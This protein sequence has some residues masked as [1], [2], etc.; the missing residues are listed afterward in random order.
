MPTLRHVSPG[1]PLKVEASTFNAFV[2]AAV[3]AREQR[4]KNKFAPRETAQSGIVLVQNRSGENVPQY[5]VLGIDEPLILPAQNGSEFLSRVM[6]KGVKPA[7]ETHTG[8]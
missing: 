2:D 5:G 8:K 6:F 7:A 1:D 3:F 4:H